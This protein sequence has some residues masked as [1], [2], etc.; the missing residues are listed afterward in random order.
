MPHAPSAALDLLAQMLQFNP[1][2]RISAADALRHPFL[3]AFHDA[4]F[5]PDCPRP[6]DASMYRLKFDNKQMLQDFAWEELFKFRP[7]LRPPKG[8]S[9][10]AKYF[11]A[12]RSRTSTAVKRKAEDVICIDCCEDAPVDRTH[13]P[14]ASAGVRVP[15]SVGVVH[16]NATAE[17]VNR[18][19]GK[20]KA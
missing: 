3:A 14:V 18:S 16:K 7:H 5:E 4:K 13:V 9:P 15:A 12:L 10:T 2:K 11:E 19:A 8:D 6:F 20:S 17:S 1:A